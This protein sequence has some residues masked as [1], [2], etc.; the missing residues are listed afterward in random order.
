MCSLASSQTKRIMATFDRLA[1]FLACGPIAASGCASS[2]PPKE[3]SEGDIVTLDGGDGSTCKDLDAQ[4]KTA[5]VTGRFVGDCTVNVAN[6]TSLVVEK[7][8]FAG[9]RLA[10]EAHG[11]VGTIRVSDVALQGANCGSGED[12]SALGVSVEAGKVESVLIERV[13]VADLCG[14]ENA[15]GIIVKTGKSATPDSGPSVTA[16]VVRDSDLTNLRTGSSEALTVEGRIEAVAI[17]RNHVRHTSNIAI[18][19]IGYECDKGL[20]DCSG[21]P[22][23][24]L[25]LDNVVSHD[26]GKCDGCAG[27]YVD[28]VSGP[29][30]IL[31]NRVE[32]FYASISAEAET[33]LKKTLGVIMIGKN[34]LHPT[35]I[36]EEHTDYAVIMGGECYTDGFDGDSDKKCFRQAQSTF[37][38]VSLAN[39]MVDSKLDLKQTCDPHKEDNKKARGGKKW[40]P[41]PKEK[42]LE[43]S[44]LAQP[45][46]K[47]ADVEL[48]QECRDLFPANRPVAADVPMEA[49]IS[50][51]T[52]AYQRA[53]R[54]EPLGQGLEHNESCLSLNET[55]P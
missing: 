31:N 18:D 22:D 6:F 21:S 40:K 27:V 23:N 50:K 25:I 17:L 33:E 32:G 45:R 38:A 30:V 44:P 43:W 15:H 26:H 35:Q 7:A 20:K 39:S 14:K 52:A 12:G 54:F 48:P 47:F 19:V 29:A 46:C 28:G 5:K 41:C 13:F 3:F 8:S 37:T 10:I 1:L 49:I 53:A 55:Q 2:P 11:Q 24:V 42:P 51:C 36:G 4:G 16:V 34:E 9:A